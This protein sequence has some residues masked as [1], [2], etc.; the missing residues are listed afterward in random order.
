M[1]LKENLMIMAEEHAESYRKQILY[2]DELQEALDVLELM[3]ERIEN[4]KSLA[5]WV[6]LPKDQD[7]NK[8]DLYEETI[9]SK[10]FHARR[11]MT[12]TGIDIAVSKPKLGV[13]FYIFFIPNRA[14]CE[15]KRYG[16]E[17]TVKYEIICK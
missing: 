3:F 2:A 11:S 7:L 9:R 5:F 13:E 10:G 1:N 15:I 14:S 6:K 17:S 16:E 12:D 4:Y 8:I